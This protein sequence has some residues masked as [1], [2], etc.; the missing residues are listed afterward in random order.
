MTDAPPY[1]PTPQQPGYPQ[2][3]YPQQGYPQQPFVQQ[4]PV[5][6]PP[7][8]ARASGNLLRRW[9]VWAQNTALIV[10]AVAVLVVVFFA[11]FFTGQANSG[12]QRGL[13]MNQDFGPRTFGGGTGAD[14]S[15]Q[16]GSGS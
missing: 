15:G 5:Q 6:Q 4:P 16:L 11:G 8:P 14:G 12:P 13:D 3:G 10:G 9:P 1:A 7:A 2:Q